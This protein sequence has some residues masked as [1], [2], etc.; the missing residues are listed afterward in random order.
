MALD[1]DSALSK[2]RR[3]LGRLFSPEWGTQC[4]KEWREKGF[5]WLRERRQ[6]ADFDLDTCLKNLEE[7]PLIREAALTAF[8]GAYLANEVPPVLSHLQF[9][10]AR[11]LLDYSP[12]P[13][14]QTK[15]LKDL[16]FV[17]LHLAGLLAIH[18]IRPDRPTIESPSAVVILEKALEAYPLAGPPGMDIDD[19]P[20]W[21][22]RCFNEDLFAFSLELVVG[23]VKTELSLIHAEQRKYEDALRLITESAWSMCATTIEDD[24]DF[25]PYLPHSGR[26]FDI[27][28]AIDI[29]EEV[30]RHAKDTRD[31]ES[32]GGYCEVLRYLGSFDLYDSTM[33]VKTSFIAEALSASEYWGRASTFAEEQNR[34]AN[35][36]FPVIT[37]DAVERTETKERLKRDFF[38]DLW[39]E[40]ERKAQEI[41]VDAEMQWMHHRA[42]NMVKEIRHVLELELPTVFPFLRPTISRS[43]SRLILTRMKEELLKNDWVRASIDGLKIDR[44]EKEWARDEL[45]E[46]LQKVIET[47]NYFEKE[48]HLSGKGAS[49]H[50]EMIE[51]AVSIHRELL[52]IG[53]EGVLPRLMKIKVAIL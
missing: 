18:L 11:N 26:G 24:P 25:E 21:G 2:F 9:E 44:C 27:Q 32:V 35:A 39:E 31:W 43:D 1:D 29:F 14:S 45:P 53:C 10:R 20:A 5:R 6:Y 23:I 47:R 16:A 15:D 52:G 13:G 36:P 7:N 3:D 38:P 30:K 19:P 8:W 48:Q 51:K 40:L 34:I 28:E 46:F 17:K 4:R 49:R 41:L 37:K 50:R 33:W 12:L 22:K 42:D